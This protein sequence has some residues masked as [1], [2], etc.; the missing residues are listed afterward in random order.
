VRDRL[1]LNWM[2]LSLSTRLNLITASALLLTMA[3]FV[4]LD[5]A[6]ERKA[7]L[8]AEAERPATLG[9]LA[10]RRLPPLPSVVT[11]EQLRAVA[12][13]SAERPVTVYL[14]RDGRDVLSSSERN[15]RVPAPK[16]VGS[17]PTYD[18]WRTS[19]KSGRFHA[20]SPRNRLRRGVRRRHRRFVS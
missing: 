5:Y 16:K 19:T 17:S 3:V 18:L 1:N 12:S 4:A 20:L 9:A 10:A 13:G 7:L 11:E 15:R 14:V 2:R 8:D 6:R